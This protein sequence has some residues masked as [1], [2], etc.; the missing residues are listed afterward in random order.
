M[1]CIAE[2][3]EK[4]NEKNNIQYIFEDSNFIWYTIGFAFG[5]L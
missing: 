4:K 2:Q 3:K 5:L 1:L